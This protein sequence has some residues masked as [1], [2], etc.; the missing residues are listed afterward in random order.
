[1][2]ALILVGGEGTRLRPL[3]STLPK[4]VVPL[5]NR[6]F[7][8][9]MLDW[10]RGHGV[11][12]VVMSCGFLATGVR[13]VLG[14][15]SS[16][17]VSLRYVEEE[18]PLG[19]AG[20]VK[21][22]QRFLDDRFLVLNGDVLTDIDLG[23]LLETH[24]SAGARATIALTPVSDPTAYGLV[25]TAADG[26]VT[27]FV[28]KPSPDEIDTDLIN[29]GAYALEREVLDLATAEESCSFERDVFPQLVGE[30]LFGARTPGYWLDIG[31]PSRYL[32]ATFDILER[33]VETA[34]GE[35]M[36][37]R[38]LSAG[39]GVVQGE[40]A[41]V[42]PPA[43]IGAGTEVGARARVGSLASVGAGSSIGPGA[44]VE[45][46]VLHQ[47][48][49]LG[50]DCVVRDSIVAA[51]VRVGEGT[52]IEGAV[53]GEGASIGAGNVLSS[54]MR[55]FPAVELPDGAVRF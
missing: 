10:L 48:V 20:A 9:Y 54:G 43:V 42:V 17:G 40:D 32:Q 6:P 44:L 33:N 23:L 19:T 30:G 12:D 37:D 21:F 53:I 18:R 46:S 38:Y 27:E 41:R 1:M 5:C 15:G 28:E 13:A 29:A 31:T 4:P 36:D 35:A 52:R 50:P 16:A 34:V 39:E 2:Q 55:L 11:D 47:R 24:Q 3:T 14:D 7:I 8:S 51:G 22:A 25:R 26:A 49:E 45:R